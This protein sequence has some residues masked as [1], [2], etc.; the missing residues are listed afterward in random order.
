MNIKREIYVNKISAMISNEQIK[1]I[2]GIS[3]CG[4]SYLLNLIIQSLKA[5]GVEDDHIIKLQM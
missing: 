2:T 5:N 4:K 1:V 3:R